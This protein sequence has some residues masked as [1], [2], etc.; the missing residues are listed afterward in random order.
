MGTHEARIDRLE[1][2][3]ND[4][5]EGLIKCV[6]VNTIAYIKL[7]AKM[8]AILWMFGIIIALG[9]TSLVMGFTL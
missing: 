6:K 9:I 5:E 8:T 1:K 2:A 3:I 4:P 7:N